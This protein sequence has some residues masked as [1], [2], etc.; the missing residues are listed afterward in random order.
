MERNDHRGGRGQEALRQEV[1][2]SPPDDGEKEVGKR[3]KLLWT[4]KTP[5]LTE[6][7]K[8]RDKTTS[9]ATFVS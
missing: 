5:G 2:P 4:D 8:K 7:K 9:N 6:S 3:R 1:L